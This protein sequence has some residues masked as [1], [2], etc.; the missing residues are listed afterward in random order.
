MNNYLQDT[1]ECF[2]KSAISFQLRAR[3]N[4]TCARRIDSKKATHNHEIAQ[5]YYKNTSY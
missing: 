4:V 5:K 3:D 2:M 1:A